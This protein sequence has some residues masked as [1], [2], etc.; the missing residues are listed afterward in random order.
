MSDDELTALAAKAY[1]YGIDIAGDKDMQR[2]VSR[3][4]PLKDNG[5]AFD[6]MVKLKL[7]VNVCIDKT[8]VDKV[9]I[10]PYFE[11]LETT[12]DA[13]VSGLAR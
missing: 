8:I 2:Y 4:K 5:P 9:G 13:P 6:I 12:L 10:I 7:I 1:F 11:E 3:W